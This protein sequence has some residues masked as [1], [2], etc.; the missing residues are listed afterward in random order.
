M[1]IAVIVVRT[2]MGLLFLVSA[3]GYFFNLMPQGEM[4]EGA[5]LFVGGMAA[6]VYLFPAVKVIET[7]CG[8]AFLSGKFVPLA[9]VIIFPITVNI[10]LFHAF[11]APDG[12]IAPVLLFAGNLFLAFHYRKKYEP[13]LAIG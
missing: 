13:V 6:S 12:M 4:S 1:K 7:L 10:L 2:L 8:L 5:S 3:I 9:T 11:L